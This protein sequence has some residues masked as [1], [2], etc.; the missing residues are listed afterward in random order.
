[1]ISRKHI[2]G[3]SLFVCKL[4]CM[5]ID[6]MTTHFYR[7]GGQFSETLGKILNIFCSIQVYSSPIFSEQLE[8]IGVGLC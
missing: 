2:V 6:T 4:K 7:N 5:E 1:M 3:S 8:A